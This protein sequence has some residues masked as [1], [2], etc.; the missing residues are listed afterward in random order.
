[1]FFSTVCSATDVD[2]VSVHRLLMNV[3]PLASATTSPPPVPRPLNSPTP[4]RNYLNSLV[5]YG[6]HTRQIVS[7]VPVESRIPGRP[8]PPLP[9]SKPLP[10]LASPLSTARPQAK[11]AQYVDRAAQGIHPD[12]TPDSRQQ[13][14]SSKRNSP[15]KRLSKYETGT[16]SSS[17]RA[18]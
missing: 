17:T 18:P 3:P 1:L 14:D 9:T 6:R 8:L 2:A 12:Q 10:P 11:V 15:V 16:R 7:I 4:P 5:L 13:N